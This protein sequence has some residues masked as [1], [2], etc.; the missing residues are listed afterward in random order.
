MEVEI[1]K[2]L[3]KFIR[4]VLLH[5]PFFDSWDEVWI[6]KSI[7]NWYREGQSID[8]FLAEFCGKEE[9]K[10]RFWE[11]SKKEMTYLTISFPSEYSNGAKIY[12]KDILHEKDGVKFSFILMKK[13]IDTQVVIE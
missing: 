7:I 4:N 5:F 11:E 12:L 10:Y 2:E 1:G 6:N 13:I 3:F 9:V 8:R